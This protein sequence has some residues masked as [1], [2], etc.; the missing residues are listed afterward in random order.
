M[1]RRTDTWLRLRRR[2]EMGEWS[3]GL[4]RRRI[5]GC[6]QSGQRER[7]EKGTEEEEEEEER[8]RKKRRRNKQGKMSLLRLLTV[9]LE[10]LRL[11]MLEARSH[12]QAL[13]GY[14]RTNHHAANLR[15]PPTALKT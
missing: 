12:D 3:M 4:C 1:V 9:S 10:D 8:K 6:W 11:L 15:S 7:T 5:W 13:L 2:V 14:A